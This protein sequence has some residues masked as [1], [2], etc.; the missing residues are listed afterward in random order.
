MYN[1]LYYSPSGYLIEEKTFST[2]AK[3]LKAKKSVRNCV[4]IKIFTLNKIEVITY[5]YNHLFS[6]MKPIH[7]R[8]N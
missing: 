2:I 1:A 7:V 4:K 3:A 6:R 8:R 5:E